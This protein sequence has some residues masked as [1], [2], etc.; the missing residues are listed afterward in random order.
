M[1]KKLTVILISLI[2]MLFTYVLIVKFDIVFESINNLMYNIGIDK[3]EIPDWVSDYKRNYDYKSF[4]MVN[5]FEP[6]SKEDIKNIFYTI[7]NNGWNNFTF[8]CPKDYNNCS[9]DVQIVANDDEFISLLNNYVSPYNSFINFNTLIT[10]GKSVYI[11]I[12]KLYSEADIIKSEEAL[13]K[14]FNK[15]S[16]ENKNITDKIKLVHNQIIRSATY[17]EQ[18]AKGNY[19]SSSNKSLGVLIDG[20][21][22]CSGYA[23]TL[24]LMLDRLNV[25]NIRVSSENHIWNAVYVNNEWTHID[26]TWDDSD[27]Y[28]DNKYNF[29]MVDTNKL[30]DLD[31]TEHKFTIDYYLELKEN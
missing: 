31:V 14:L 24:A 22:V 6:H 11:T 17:D 1:T 2:I 9:T 26:V 5:N 30:L 28:E 13:D 27:S 16:F 23:D 7:L 20:K 25:P 4:T 12:D 8:Y 21:A 3:V 18:Y 10:G 29:F 19:I 15:L